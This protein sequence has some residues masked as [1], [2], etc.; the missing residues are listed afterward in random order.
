MEILLKFSI[1][2]KTIL[3]GSTLAATLLL[4]ACVSTKNDHNA[5]NNSNKLVQQTASFSPRA[6]N[7]YLSQEQ[8]FKRSERVSKVS[9]QLDFNG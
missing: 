7:K 1:S 6:E 8:A 9:Y 3:A 4:S 5:Q 2:K